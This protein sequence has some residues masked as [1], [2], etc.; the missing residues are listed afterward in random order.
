MIGKDRID[1]LA[2]SAALQVAARCI[3]VV[4]VPAGLAM[5]FWLFATVRNLETEVAKLPTEI[6]RI[7]DRI[8][9][10]SRRLDGQDQRLQRLEE[11]YFRG[12]RGP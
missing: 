8:S 2:H 5:M 7:Q 1:Q 10:V 9:D 6:Q 12:G 3:Q 11:P 4:G